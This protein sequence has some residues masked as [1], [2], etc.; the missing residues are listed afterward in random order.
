MM[1]KLW[2][3]I[4]DRIIQSNN[5]CSEQIQLAIQDAYKR[6]LFPSLTNE[7]LQNS[8]RKSR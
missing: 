8:K 2:H 4:E 1:K 7:A 6:L 3:K 5:A